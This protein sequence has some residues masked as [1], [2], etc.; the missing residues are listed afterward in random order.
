MG[1]VLRARREDLKRDFAL[2]VIK[3]GGGNDAEAVARFRREAQAA[4]QLAGHP[5]IVGCHDVGEEDGRVYFAMDFVEGE[6]LEQLI[7]AGD[8]AP[9]RAATLLA[10]A[11]R[12]VQHAHDAGILHRDLKP[13]NLMVTPD[14]RALVTD[15]G[16]A[17]S[18][19][20]DAESVRLTQSGVVLGTP[21]YMAPEQARGG[22]LT[23]AADV[24]ALGATLYEALLGDTPFQADSMHAMLLQV[25]RDEPKP[26]RKRD[27]R[28]PGDLDTITL[29]C[30]EKEPAE[31]YRSA[32]EL[33]DDLE[34]YLAG[35]AIQ[36]Q[37]PSAFE[38]LRRRIRRNRAPYLVGAAGVAAVLV[39]G[40]WFG[41]NWWA[42]RAGRAEA[43]GGRAAAQDAAREQLRKRA[44][45]ALDAALDLRR[46]GAVDKMA[47]YLAETETACADAESAM[48][49]APDPHYHRGRFFRAMMRDGDALAAQEAALARDP[50][51]A[52]A[53][54]ERI[55]LTARLL[56]AR[57]EVVLAANNQARGSTLTLGQAKGHSDSLD[58]A[59]DAAGLID[60]DPE[61]VRLLGVLRADIEQL[62][63]GGSRPAG[64]TEAQWACIEGIGAWAVRDDPPAAAALTRAL[65]LDPDLLEARQMHASLAER[66]GDWPVAAERWDA[67]VE[68]DLGFVANR[69]RRAFA[70]WQAGIRFNLEG[71]NPLPILRQALADFDQLLEVFP[72]D[73]Q[74]RY[75]RASTRQSIAEVGIRAGQDPM[76]MLTASLADATRMQ[77]LDPSHHRG[78][79][80][81]AISLAT[82]ATYLSKRGKP[83]GTRWDDAAAAFQEAVRL[84]PGDISTRLMHGNYWSEH[85]H[86]LRNSGRDAGQSYAR[87]AEEYDLAIRINPT[88]SVSWRLRALAMANWGG[89]LSGAGGDPREKW[90]EALRL[91]EELVRRRPTDAK[92][93]AL[94]GT[95]LG[96]VGD[97]R[98]R[99]GQDPSEH[100]RLAITDHQ[101]A[102]EIDPTDGENWRGLGGVLWNRAQFARSSG[103]DAAPGL[104]EADAAYQRAIDL[105]PKDHRAWVG[106]GLTAAE[107]MHLHRRGSPPFMEAMQ[108]AAGHYQEALKHHPTDWRT[109]VHLGVLYMN[110]GTVLMSSRR[111]P[112]AAYTRSLEALDRA[113]EANP[114]DG[115][116]RKRRG[117]TAAK[118]GAYYWMTKQDPTAMWARAEAD[119][120]AALKAQ[121]TDAESWYE[122]GLLHRARSDRAHQLGADP[123]PGAGKSIAA[124]E[125]AIKHN[126]RL[127]PSLQPVIDG[128]RKRLGTAK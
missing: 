33:A 113:V 99:H 44:Q 94:R 61:S 114:A 97:W 73:L 38:L 124:Y 28:I 25:L 67:A 128:L 78:W 62:R 20:A 90:T 117:M 18:H 108:R 17:R 55:V 43:E 109:W 127:A 12:A 27:P 112:T 105:D 71:G 76:P 120:E 110:E 104:Q 10:Q 116:A 5:G 9:H 24:Y 126:P 13:A 42:E 2:K 79:Q 95:W 118:Q 87:A 115:I 121:P 123:A 72:D 7:D 53:R 54:Y 92:L 32:G 6:S 96:E 111:D 36:A 35:D 100:Y 89:Y 69:R 68:R 14:N 50:R 74:L 59:V 86:M 102:A 4:A 107:E 80:L 98:R 66:V 85:A 23:P 31:R 34:R 103:R 82:A 22:T 48:P 56:D 57:Y 65:E 11:A 52:G 91:M 106:R 40:G 75:R 51:H 125:Q 84:A 81:R 77:E 26:L 3:G 58:L 37:P 122:L 15:F 60:S 8:L 83:V 119:F 21:A 49:R 93:F 70:R 1:V 45:L 19:N 30:L 16:L 101:R 41:S 63:S 46:L 88:N 29:K 47:R 39:I 64:L